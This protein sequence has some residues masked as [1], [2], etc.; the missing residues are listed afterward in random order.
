MYYVLVKRFDEMV[1]LAKWQSE[2]K[3]HSDA[4]FRK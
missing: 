2:N 4:A 1:R 3:C